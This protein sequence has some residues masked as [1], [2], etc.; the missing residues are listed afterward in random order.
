MNTLEVKSQHNSRQTLLWIARI[1]ASLIIAFVMTF[2]LAHTYGAIFE[3][4]GSP[5]GMTLQD[6]LLFT[7]FPVSTLIGLTL[8]YKWEL[9]GGTIATAALILMF[10][11]QITLD[12][13][14]GGTLPGLGEIVKQAGIFLFFI[15]PPGILYMIYGILQ[16]RQHSQ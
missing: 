13:M 2:V 8:A 15:M 1:W 16:K 6:A 4:Q 11:M 10:T 5:N 12:I 9:L 7:C 3:G 14:N